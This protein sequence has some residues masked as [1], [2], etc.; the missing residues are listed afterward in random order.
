M[1]YKLI[2]QCRICG[3][4]DLTDV[5]SFPAQFLSPTF[6][7]S[8]EKNILATI[9][10]PLTV[11]LCN[12]HKNP[13]GCGLVQLRE[14]TDHN[15]LYT[16]YFYR[17]A[18]NATMRRDL[19]NV[20]DDVMSRAPLSAGD[21]VVDI[22]SNDGT[23]LTYFPS[24]LVR[25]G[26]E[27]AKNISWEALDPEI[28]VVNDYFSKSALAHA[29]AGRKVKVFTSCAM[30][31]DLDDP[32]IFVSEIKELLA[33]DGIF[34][35]Q[36]SYLVSMLKNMN[37]YDVC[38]EHLEYY[39]LTV[40]NSLME[41]NGLSIFDAETNAVNGGSVRVFI[42]HTEHAPHESQN[43]RE[44]LKIENE[45]HLFDEATYREFYEK[46]MN[47]AR[48]IKEY[49]YSE[50]QKGRLVIGLGASTKGNVLLQ[51]FGID[52]TMLPYISEINKEKIGKRTLGTDIELISD[53]RASKLKPSAKLV[54]PWY[55][56]EEIVKREE[57]YL[58]QG[59]K[60]LFP[61]PSAH[62]VTR[63]GKQALSL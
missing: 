8:N 3:S 46:I 63:E 62:I 12:I 61:M 1:N 7:E 60:L 6:V 20:V 13:K 22:G 47:L 4:K 40:L 27:P 38:H 23:M 39:S 16:N 9:K 44:L 36:L 32:N 14:T 26:V 35:I 41:R 37:F 56:K 45:M 31:Y 51:L 34:C 54:L 33:P 5:F 17:S 25:I 52:N 24:N 53:E 28:C 43:L 10:V 21:V 18:T 57:S 11:T 59:G 29:L 15:L 49:I 2:N 55:F 48:T 50:I 30:F 42:T 19:K 58:R